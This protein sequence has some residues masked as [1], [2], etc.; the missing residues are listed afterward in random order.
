MVT[1]RGREGAASAEEAKVTLPAAHLTAD[2]GQY[3]VHVPSGQLY[4]RTAAHSLQAA[5]ISCEQQA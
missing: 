4:A 2:G 1:R 5:L 3:I